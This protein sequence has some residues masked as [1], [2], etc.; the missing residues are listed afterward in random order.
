MNDKAVKCPG[1]TNAA[2]RAMLKNARL[3]PGVK[4]GGGGG[5][6]RAGYCWD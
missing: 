6:G 3:M 1:L 2:R 4:G 5:G